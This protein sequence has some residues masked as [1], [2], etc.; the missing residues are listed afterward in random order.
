MKQLIALALAATMVV[1]GASPLMAANGDVN[2][3][4][5]GV[6][7]RGTSAGQIATGAVVGTVLIGG[8]TFL[9]T[10]R[11]N[12]DTAPDSDSGHRGPTPFLIFTHGSTHIHS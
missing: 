3:Q 8:A 10:N 7:N 1:A 11:R 6:P 2:V 12:G 4:S 5:G 9:L